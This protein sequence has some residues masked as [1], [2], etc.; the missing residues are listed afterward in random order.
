MM[1]NGC[2]SLNLHVLIV[3]KSVAVMGDLL[4]SSRD[5]LA[6]KMGMLPV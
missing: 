5:L 3:L 6:R 2:G 1:S 4:V